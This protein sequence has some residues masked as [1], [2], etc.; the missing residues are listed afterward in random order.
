MKARGGGE[1]GGGDKEDMSCMGR[2][3]R[4]EMREREEG[5]GLVRIADEGKSR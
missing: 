3:E 4:G 2:E 1:D 5:C